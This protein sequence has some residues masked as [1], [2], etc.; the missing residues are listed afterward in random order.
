MVSLLCAIITKRECAAGAGVSSWVAVTT[1][2]GP[3]NCWIAWRSD[4]QR[5]V[6]HCRC[7]PT[8]SPP[9][10]LVICADLD[11]LGQVRAWVRKRAGRGDFSDS[12]LDDIDLAVTEAVSN[13]IRHAYGGQSDQHVTIGARFEGPRFVV[14]ILDTGPPFEK[15]PSARPLDSPHE[16]GYGLQLISAVMDD[17]IRTRLPDGHNELRLVR[18]RSRP[19]RE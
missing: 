2:F 12:D 8:V 11:L 19:E 13:V 10:L 7:H 15:T 18:E 17:V 6:G 1:R 14:S 5:Q 3:P 4:D 9:D 16:G